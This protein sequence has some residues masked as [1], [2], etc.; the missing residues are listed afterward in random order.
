MRH[1]PVQTSATT[2]K[3]RPIA[4][5]RRDSRTTV[6]HRHPCRRTGVD[7]Y[8]RHRLLQ[9]HHQSHRQ[10]QQA[11]RGAVRTTRPACAGDL[12]G[13]GAAGTGPY[14][15]G[16][17]RCPCCNALFLGARGGRIDQRIARDIVHKQPEPP[18]C[19]ISV[20]TPCGIPRPRTS[21]DGGADLREV[22]EMLGHSSL[23]TTQ[24]YTHV[25]IE[26]LK[27]RYGQTFPRA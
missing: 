10:R 3:S 18:E 5:Q 1:P 16:C 14:G 17:S 12:A 23:K 22:Q 7:G 21:V 11:T 8:R 2:P 19:R 6:C 26:Q 27:N 9:S 15:N 24:R 4:A 20:P 13:T 25:S